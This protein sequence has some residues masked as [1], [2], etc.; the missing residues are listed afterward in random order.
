MHHHRALVVQWQPVIAFIF[1]LSLDFFS[2]FSKARLFY[3]KHFISFF[4]FA[5]SQCWSIFLLGR[6]RG[7]V[8]YRM[9]SKTSMKCLCSLEQNHHHHPLAPPTTNGCS[10]LANICFMYASLMASAAIDIRFISFNVAC[11]FPVHFFNSFVTFLRCFVERG[12]G[13]T[14]TKCEQF[15]NYVARVKSEWSRSSEF[16][17]P[18]T[19]STLI[20]SS[21]KALRRTK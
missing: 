18:N 14:T 4:F 21:W 6:K 11:F 13:S 2:Y 12:L 1:C 5:L 20:I 16:T 3:E 10:S 17:S 19:L 15:Q 8:V 9:F 7:W